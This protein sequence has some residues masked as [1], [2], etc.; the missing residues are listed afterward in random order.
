MGKDIT[1]LD[2]DEDIA[3]RNVAFLIVF[4]KH[5]KEWYTDQIEKMVL[6]ERLEHALN[7]LEFLIISSKEDSGDELL[8][9]KPDSYQKFIASLSSSIRKGNDNI[10]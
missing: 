3:I 5:K 1:R 8:V 7:F 4:G 10:Q 2:I 9:Y 6:P